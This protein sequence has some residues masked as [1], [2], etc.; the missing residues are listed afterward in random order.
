M[1]RMKSLTYGTLPDR[2]EFVRRVAP[3]LK[4]EGYE[5][6]LV[7]DDADWAIEVINQ[8][9][10]SHLE[11]IRFT[12]GT[13]RYGKLKITIEDAGSLHTFLRRL[14]DLPFDYD[15]EDVAEGKAESPESFVSSVMYTLGYEWI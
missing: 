6:E 12:E 5:M 3:K 1:A 2:K 14:L 13:G 15:D 9:I 8:G 7:G 11:A 4:D 10:D